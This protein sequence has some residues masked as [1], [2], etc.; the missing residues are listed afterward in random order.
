[1]LT[2][3]LFWD[4]WCQGALRAPT[5]PGSAALGSSSGSRLSWAL[6]ARH[7]ANTSWALE[8]SGRGAGGETGFASLLGPSCPSATFSTTSQAAFASQLFQG[9]KRQ[10]GF[11]S[12]D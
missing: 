12:K 8:G 5:Q 2:G 6:R 3:V 10:Q 1:M 4:R 7:E 11:R 9:T